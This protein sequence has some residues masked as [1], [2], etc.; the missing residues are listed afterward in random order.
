MRFEGTIKS[1]NDDR[2][3]GFIEP[4]HGGQEIF[5]HIKATSRLR[6]RPKPG[7]HV[8]FQVEMDPHGKKRA[9]DVKPVQALRIAQSFQ[10]ESPARWA[11][12]SILAIPLLLFVLLAGYA[13]GEPPRWVLLVYPTVSAITY[14]AY[15]LDKSAAREG[16]RRTPEKTLHMLTLIGGWPGALVAQQ[17]F[18]HKSS[19]LEFRKIFWSTVALNITAFILLSSPYGKVLAGT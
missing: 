14:I 9:F 18:R 7:H 8:T 3:F 12:A 6:G 5:V 16:A 10:K 13:L 19:K 15:A 1:W 4:T 17:Q 2:G 11:I